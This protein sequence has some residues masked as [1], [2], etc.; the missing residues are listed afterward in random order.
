[1]MLLYIVILMIDCLQKQSVL[2]AQQPEKHDLKENRP[3]KPK[4]HKKKKNRRE[5]EMDLMVF[6]DDDTT[7]DESE[8]DEDDYDDDEHDDDSDEVDDSYEN[9]ND[10]EP[11]GP[12]N[13]TV[14]GERTN[15]H[16]G[17]AIN[18]HNPPPP[19]TRESFDTESLR[20]PS[21]PSNISGK[22][23][24]ISTPFSYGGAF[25]A[26]PLPC[27]SIDCDDHMAASIIFQGPRVDKLLSHVTSKITQGPLFSVD[28]NYALHQVRVT[29]LHANHA[30]QFLSANRT[31]KLA[32]GSSILGNG[33]SLVRADMTEWDNRIRT[34]TSEAQN[35][36]ARR[37]L[38]FSR[39]GF[40]N[41]DMPWNKFIRDILA[42]VRRK[43]YIECMWVI[44]TGN[45]TFDT[46]LVP[47]LFSFN[48]VCKSLFGRL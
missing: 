31:R 41:H 28:F 26:R 37:R 39:A 3:P 14:L 27:R 8:Y 29:F 6:S 47:S 38:M 20:P 45:G 10:N 15:E 36:R 4:K 11:L 34:M 46:T 17:Y 9:D 33:W 13:R 2:G 5:D 24:P 48:P 18:T 35:L 25:R 12:G 1:M 40:I 22:D 7:D 19:K 16:I 21:I 32:T 44:N 23:I 30:I 42:V 43:D